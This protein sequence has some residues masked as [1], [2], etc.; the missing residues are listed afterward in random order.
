MSPIF[1]LIAGIFILT[2]VLNSV[3]RRKMREEALRQSAE[4]EKQA[5]AAKAQSAAENPAAQAAKAVPTP[6]VRP[7]AS[8]PIEGQRVNTPKPLAVQAQVAYE[9][10]RSEQKKQK[11]V[12]AAD[13][14]D[15]KTAP[16]LQWNQN[17]ALQG[18]MYAEILGKPKALRRK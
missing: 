11:P 2:T 14:T 1:V 10:Q 8:V 9:K 6:T 16:L 13:I 18:I 3:K 12:P 15:A 5:E 7:Q 17:S 4:R